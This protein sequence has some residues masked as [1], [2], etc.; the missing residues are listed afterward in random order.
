MGFFDCCAQGGAAGV[1]RNPAVQS[2]M[3]RQINDPI[4]VGGLAQG[5]YPHGHSHEFR[6]FFAGRMLREQAC[7]L[8]LKRLA[9]RIVAVN[10]L[11]CGDADAGACPGAAFEQAFKFEP[12]EGF[13]N[14]QET[15]AQFRRDLAA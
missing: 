9:H 3:Q 14:R 2:L 8:N 11:L 6:L 1:L 13:R 10:I 7:G 12:H 4:G 15:H 5:V